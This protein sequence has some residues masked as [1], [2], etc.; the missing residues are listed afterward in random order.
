MEQ[1]INTIVDH[2]IENQATEINNQVVQLLQED[3]DRRIDSVS[4]VR[5]VSLVFPR[6]PVSPLASLQT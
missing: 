2:K 1:R 3:I 4:A 6:N 5:L